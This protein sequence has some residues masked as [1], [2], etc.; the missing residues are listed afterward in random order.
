MNT[1]RGIFSALINSL[2]TLGITGLSP[3]QIGIK[4]KRTNGSTDS[5]YSSAITLLVTALPRVLPVWQ[6]NTF[7][8]RVARGSDNPRL[9]LLEECQYGW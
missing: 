6:C 9:S 7:Q 1:K 8:A 5:K 3:Q 2:P 4:A